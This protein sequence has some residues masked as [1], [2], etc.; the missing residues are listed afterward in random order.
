MRIIVTALLCG[1]WSLSGCAP[2]RKLTP[3]QL[4]LPAP[5]SEA[6]KPCTIPALRGGDAAAVD[7]ALIERGAAIMACEAKRRALVAGW[8]R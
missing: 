4:Q 8:P 1:A 5:P 6:M 7:A 3:P 2:S